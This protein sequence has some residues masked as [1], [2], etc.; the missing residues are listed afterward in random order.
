MLKESTKNY[1]YN[2]HD[3]EV[4]Q[5]YNKTLPYSFHLELVYLQGLKFIHL[6]PD[7]K[8]RPENSFSNDRL[9]DAVLI[10]CIG[11]DSI[12]DARLTYND[13]KELYGVEVAEMIYLVT[14]NKGRN[15]LARKSDEYYQDL[16]SNPLAVFVKLCDLMANIKFGILTN[17]T[18]LSKYKSEYPNI[19]EKLYSKEYDEMFIYIDSLLKI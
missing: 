14:D 13:I 3:V 6:I 11:H 2:L 8:L 4:N 17:S 7:V 9:R 12:E 5:K 18:M 19:R 10:A 15:R 16:K 1:F